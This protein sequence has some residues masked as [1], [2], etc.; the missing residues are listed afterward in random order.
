VR[1]ILGER[2]V[3]ER[4]K[5]VEGGDRRVLMRQ[6]RLA[7]WLAKQLRRLAEWVDTKQLAQKKQLPLTK[8]ELNRFEVTVRTAQE[9]FA[10]WEVLEDP[11]SILRQYSN[12][13]GLA[14]FY[15]AARHA[16]LAATILALWTLY[17]EHSDAVSF[18]RYSDEFTGKSST[19]PIKTDYHWSSE[20]ARKKLTILR[21]KFFA[22]QDLTASI[23]KTFKEADLKRTE[24]QELI[25]RSRSLLSFLASRSSLSL[26]GVTQSP[27]AGVETEKLLQY[28]LRGGG[29]RFNP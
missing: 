7:R 26:N 3:R 2:G 13:N 14:N 24:I 8:E 23:S 4:R 29:L 27:R 1:L 19:K 11:K 10:V 18:R 25:A 15:W 16:Y 28:V 20:L 9:C 12:F 22:H 5:E 21:H 17:D 6:S